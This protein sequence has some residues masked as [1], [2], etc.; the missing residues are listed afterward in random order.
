MIDLSRPIAVACHDAGGANVVA[1]LVARFPDG[2]RAYVEGPARRIWAG[3]APCPSCRS[4]AEAMDGVQSLLTSTSVGST[5]EHDA[6]KLARIRGMKSVAVLDHWTR[7]R[8]RFEMNGELV[9]PDEIWVIDEPAEMKVRRCLP[10]IPI[11]RIPNYY[12]EGQI[13][14]IETFAPSPPRP[15]AGRIL[16]VLEPIVPQWGGQDL[17]PKELQAFDFFMSHLYELGARPDAE[18]VL[19]PHP[20]DPPGKYDS[21]PAYYPGRRVSVN[22]GP[23]LSSQIAWADWVVGCE[24]FALVIANAAGRITMSTLPPWAP[25]CRIPLPALQQMSD[26]FPEAQP[27]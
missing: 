22:A 26:R 14:E 23:S 2:V 19:R 3:V 4:L 10:S 25:K 21:W 12:L 20:S 16:Y 15:D 11:R 9:L 17:R 7:Y 27:S 24:T 5:L 13:R 1:S 8:E 18:I 6:R